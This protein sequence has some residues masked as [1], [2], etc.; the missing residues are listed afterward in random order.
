MF[1]PTSFNTHPVAN[2]T[3]P[4]FLSLESVAYEKK[5]E[6][7]Y[8]IKQLFFYYLFLLLC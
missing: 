3:V 5:L 4:S 2:L 7:F 8:R 1:K 6:N